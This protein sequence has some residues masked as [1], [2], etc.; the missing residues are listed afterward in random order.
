VNGVCCEVDECAPGEFCAAGTGMCTSGATFTPT[1]TPTMTPTASATSTASATPTATATPTPSV[2]P[3]PSPGS[4]PQSTATPTPTP[5][6]TTAMQDLSSLDLV[7]GDSAGTCG[8]SRDGGGAVVRDLIC[9]TIYAG[10]GGSQAPP[11]GAQR[12]RARFAVTGCTGTECTLGPTTSDQSGSLDC[13]DTG[14]PIGPPVRNTD[15]LP[16]CSATAWSGPAEGSVDLSAGSASILLH[17]SAHTWLTTTRDE[18]CPLCVGGT[19]NRGARAGLPCSTNDP[20]GLTPECVPGGTDG[21]I[22][23]GFLNLDVRL[24]TDVLHVTT[25]DGAF[26]AGQ[27][28]IRPGLTGCFGMRNC[29]TIDAAGAPAAGGLLPAGSP[30]TVTLAAVACVPQTGNSL[31]DSASDLPGPAMESLSATITLNP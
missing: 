21:S 11:L 14:C 31:I 27:D 28:A 22:D 7:A 9:G 18:P 1:F 25:Q 13:T 8:A 4:T 23:L 20:D 30:H 24:T 2:T 15:P 5:T 19:C 6:P 10:G 12:L 26:C 17:A 29:R 3:T 16:T